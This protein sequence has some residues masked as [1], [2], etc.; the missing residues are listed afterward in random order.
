[1]SH[2]T[3]DDLAIMSKS[4]QTGRRLSSR[5]QLF[6]TSVQQDNKDMPAVLSFFFMLF[7]V[8]LVVVALY[9]RERERE[10]VSSAKIA[11]QLSLFR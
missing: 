3:A 7:V 1:M 11:I 2:V 6:L 10:S 9:R 8:I 4:C 5:C